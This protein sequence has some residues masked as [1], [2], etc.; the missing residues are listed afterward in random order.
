MPAAVTELASAVSRHTNTPTRGS[1]SRDMRP[2]RWE[3]NSG[4]DLLSKRDV[5]FNAKTCVGHT[6]DA[7]RNALDGVGGP[8]DT[9]Y[10]SWAAFDVFAGYLAFDAWIA[11]TDRHA[12]N[13]EVIQSPTER[14]CLA[15][16]FDHGAA[17]GS[18]IGE[19]SHARVVEEGVEKW[20][21]NGF[22]RRFEGAATPH[23]LHL[24]PRRLSW[25]T[26]RPARIGRR[27]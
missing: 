2:P 7:I 12:L 5:N 21:R 26:D 1:I 13:W 19:R 14:M 16:S 18:G 9:R 25:P 15:P 3:R 4:A 17:L 11:N 8:P 6:P 22:G 23:S 20:C 10:E 27:G 24:P